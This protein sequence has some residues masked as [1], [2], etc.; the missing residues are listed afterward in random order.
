ML[1][2][3]KVGRKCVKPSRKTRNGRSARVR[4]RGTLTRR[5]L[6]AARAVP[7]TGRIGKKKLPG[8][9]YRATVVAT[10]AAG[11]KSRATVE[12]KV[13]RR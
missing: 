10:D 3:R 5:N 1:P 2:G 11:N 7:F 9:K 12:F 4:T 13:V 6:P 8:G